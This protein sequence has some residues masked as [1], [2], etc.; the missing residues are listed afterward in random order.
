MFQM[1]CLVL[2]FVNPLSANFTKWSN[3]QTIRRQFADELF[4][5]VFDHFVGLTLK[6]LSYNFCISSYNLRYRFEEWQHLWRNFVTQN[7]QT[8]SVCYLTTRSRYLF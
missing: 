7:S 1:S 6:G 8:S 3:T 2:G 4:E 5:S